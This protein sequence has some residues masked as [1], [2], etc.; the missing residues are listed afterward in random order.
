MRILKIIGILLIVFGFSQLL[1]ACSHSKNENGT[2]YEYANN[3]KKADSWIKIKSD[4]KWSD[5]D[6]VSGTYQIENGEITFYSEVLGSNEEL[7][8]G[9]INNGIIILSIGNSQTEYRT[10]DASPNNDSGNEAQTE[11]TLE[12]ALNSNN[13]KFTLGDNGLTYEA[14]GISSINL[15][16]YISV[17]EHY[18]GT[19]VDSNNHP[20]D[21]TEAK[22]LPLGENQFYLNIERLAD[23]KWKTFPIIINCKANVT[24]YDENDMD[25]LSQVYMR[26]DKIENIPVDL[27][28]GYHYEW[29]KDEWSIDLDTFTFTSNDIDLELYAREVPNTYQIKYDLNYPSNDSN[30]TDTLYYDDTYYLLNPE[31]EG[32]TF[33]GWYTDR[34]QGTLIAGNGTWKITQ[35]VTVYARWEIKNYN[36]IVSSEDNSVGIIINQN[37]STIDYNQKV[38]IKAVTVKNDYQFDGWFINHQLITRNLD[39]TFYMPNNN[40][41]I[42][43]K[44]FLPIYIVYLNGNGFNNDENNVVNVTY[45]ENYSLPTLDRDGYTFDGW[46]TEKDGGI[47]FDSVGTWNTQ[48]D[49]TLFAHWII[50]QYTVTTSSNIIEACQLS[51]QGSYNYDTIVTI[52]ATPNEGYEF[53]GW[54]INNERITTDLTYSFVFSSDV[55]Y[56]SRW[57]LN[58]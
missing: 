53:L 8:S 22:N 41:D 57:S 29:Y 2:Y 7:M 23:G 43:A 9:T 47:K 26:D 45:T 35:N 21:I 25:I 39:Y 34:T 17:K 30:Q 13:T 12:E 44:W 49:I 42:Q 5:D 54:Y 15:P 51:G 1:I 58:N 48:N 33:L 56:I 55:E 16:D 50:N 28:E 4:N 20:I 27:R 31:R 37:N 24:F 3:E 32:F 10:N 19:F 14:I 6:N 40:V 36:L 46:Y 11:V 38:T 18:K 52:S